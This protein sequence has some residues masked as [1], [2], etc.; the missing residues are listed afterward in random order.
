MKRVELII[1]TACRNHGSLGFNEQECFYYMCLSVA[2]SLLENRMGWIYSDAVGCDPNRNGDRSGVVKL[3]CPGCKVVDPRNVLYAD[4]ESHDLHWVWVQQVSCLVWRH[5][6]HVR[7][8]WWD[9]VRSH[10]QDNIWTYMK[11]F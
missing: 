3:F 1:T 6:R 10:K 9:R 4:C 8:V 5:V 2:Y 7:V 11:R